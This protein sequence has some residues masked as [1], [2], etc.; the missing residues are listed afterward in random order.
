MKSKA[1]IHEFISK[2]GANPAFWLD[3]LATSIYI[4]QCPAKERAQQNAHDKLKLFI[5]FL[6][7]DQNEV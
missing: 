4:T 5:D 7:E 2:N 6:M 1:E 3:A